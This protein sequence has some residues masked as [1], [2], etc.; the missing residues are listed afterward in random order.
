MSKTSICVAMLL[1]SGL[2]AGACRSGDGKAEAV[3]QGD[4]LLAQQRYRPAAAAYRSALAADPSDETVRAK[5]GEAL[6]GAGDTIRAADLLAG[7]IDAQLKAAESMLTRGRFDDVRVRMDEVLQSHPDNAQ[8]LMLHA[9]ALAR[10]SGD[11]NALFAL[12]DK[13]DQPRRLAPARVDLRPL[14]S[15]SD[16]QKA[17]AELKKAIALDPANSS[18]QLALANL[19]WATGRF[20]EAEPLLRMFTAQAAGHA[21]AN[22]ALGAYYLTRGRESEADA[23]LVNAAAAT[24]VLGRPARFT[25]A[26]RYIATHRPAEAR[27]LLDSMLPKE[28]DEGDVSVRLARLEA[29]AGNVPDAVRRLDAALQ[30]HPS[31]ASGLLL[32][33]QL[34]FG[35]GNPDPRFARAAVMADPGSSEAR[36]LLGDILA[37]AGDVDGA[38]Q[39]FR[40]AVSRDPTDVAPRVALVRALLAN[41]NGREALPVARDAVRLAPTHTDAVLSLVAAE[42]ALQHYDEAAAALSPL[43][44]RAPGSPDVAVA[45]GRLYMARGNGAAARGAFLRALQASPDSLDA[46]HGLVDTEPAGHPAPDTVRRVDTALAARPGDAAL[47]LVSSRLFAS[48]G[49]RA[50]AESLLRRA[51]VLEPSNVSLALALADALSSGGRVEEAIDTLTR[52]VARH[53]PRVTDVRVSLASLLASVGRRK[54]AQ[55][56]HEQILIEDPERTDSAIWLATA[57]VDQSDRLIQALELAMTAKRGRPDDPDVDLL[58]GR[59]YTARKL[60]LLA[61]PALQ[62]AVNARPG[63][64]LYHFHLGAAYEVG[65]SLSQA[66][67]EYARALEL[68]STFPGAEKAREMTA[69]RR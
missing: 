8:A 3:R 28:D 29:G 58:L 48:M 39:E 25:L 60:G 47:M 46:L 11:G 54:E 6:A 53:P 17:E 15:S 23:Y 69:A 4:A 22:H 37:A 64:A 2:L 31:N 65:G 12:A 45:E 33:A 50:R 42:M 59:V 38:L 41:G 51:C 14:V 27:A 36:L 21:A 26:D 13:L 66:R 68:D 61:V 44:V 34:L 52:L 7:D 16:D 20:D 56:E 55:E 43:L 30:R 18:L 35:R 40:E 10:L 57:Y 63:N 1:V 67:A 19:Y 9:N 49:D 32:K 5:L 24:G 62:R